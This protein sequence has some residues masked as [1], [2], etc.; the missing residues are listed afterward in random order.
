MS[1]WARGVVLAALLVAC[2]EREAHACTF[3][4]LDDMIDISVGPARPDYEGT[5]RWESY[6]AAEQ[7]TSAALGARPYAPRVV[8]EPAC[9][10]VAVA[11]N[12]GGSL[13]FAWPEAESARAAFEQLPVAGSLARAEDLRLVAVERAPDFVRFSYERGGGEVPCECTVVLDVV[14]GRGLVSAQAARLE[15]YEEHP[16]Q[17]YTRGEARAAV[18]SQLVADS[19]T[20]VV[21]EYER[22]YLTE[23]LVV[24]IGDF[25]RL[26]HRF[27]VRLRGLPYVVDV[28]D[29]TLEVARVRPDPLFDRSAPRTYFYPAT[30][31]VLTLE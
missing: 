10:I 7:R 28:D 29:R 24:P 16:Q 20:F 9:R 25:A 8:C 21:D 27:A 3:G 22:S 23:L 1:A 17:R 5:A 15:G 31:R 19:P 4:T 2:A 11:A 14:P 18:L 12:T 30:G 6:A 26:V 13:G